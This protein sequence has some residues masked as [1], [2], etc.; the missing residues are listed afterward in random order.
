M[1]FLCN[2][3]TLLNG[4]TDSSCIRLYFL[5][6]KLF[7]R[8]SE[9]DGFDLI[10]YLIGMFCSLRWICFRGDD[11]ADDDI[12]LRMTED[13]LLC[14]LLAIVKLELLLLAGL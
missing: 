5:R 8:L 14:I 10:N 13:I 4:F 3:S 1:K 9:D 2:L 7:S 11:G 12:F 6:Y